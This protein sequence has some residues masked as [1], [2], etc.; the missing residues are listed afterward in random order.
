MQ[1]QRRDRSFLPVSIECGATCMPVGDVRRK[2]VGWDPRRAECARRLAEEENCRGSCCTTQ[3]GGGCDVSEK[4]GDRGGY[5]MIV[6]LQAVNL[7][8]ACWKGRLTEKAKRLTL[9][10]RNNDGGGWNNNDFET[11]MIHKI[12][13]VTQK[14]CVCGMQKRG[15]VKN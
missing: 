15:G 10:D 7:L 9:R 1:A 12:L 8:W 4:E 6:N 2:R 13:G 14:L 3:Q 5:Q 11:M